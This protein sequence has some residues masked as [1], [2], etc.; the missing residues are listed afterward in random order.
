MSK[1][2][3]SGLD[4][5]NLYTYDQALALVNEKLIVKYS[6]TDLLKKI[7]E[8]GY[9]NVIGRIVDS[10]GL[11]DETQEFEKR[12]GSS[13]SRTVTLDIDC[14]SGFFALYRS[15]NANDCLKSLAFGLTEK[16]G[17]S[18]IFVIDE[19]GNE[20][21]AY[22]ADVGDCEI[23]SIVLNEQWRLSKFGAGEPDYIPVG[24][25]F[26]SFEMLYIDKYA[27]DIFIERFLEENRSLEQE[28]EQE[29][30]Q[31]NRISVKGRQ[32]SLAKLIQD[33]F[34]DP[35]NIPKG[36]LSENDIVYCWYKKEFDLGVD[37]FK[38]DLGCL[39]DKGVYKSIH[40]TRR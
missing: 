11:L 20:Y 35:M 29:Q 28:Q 25:Y 33:T 10:V 32:E 14:F 23:A 39:R 34:D 38:K 37:T 36:K 19:E 26:M 6:K 24:E 27:L 18:S 12:N 15:L 31:E 13:L 9:P 8:V 1:R 17:I 16:K 3:V 30:E 5:S 2:R 40:D 21:E 7:Y 4:A 22:I